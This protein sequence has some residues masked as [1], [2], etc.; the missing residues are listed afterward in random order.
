MFY[1][2]A[3]YYI[4]RGVG[5]IMKHELVELV[6]HLLC[7]WMVMCSNLAKSEASFLFC[8]NLFWRECEWAEEP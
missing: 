5:I 8:Q 2:G 1:N 4:P 6:V 3:W 7:N